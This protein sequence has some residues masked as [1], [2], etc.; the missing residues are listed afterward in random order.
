MRPLRSG[1]AARAVPRA[2]GSLLSVLVLC[3]TGPAAAAKPYRIAAAVR[4][5]EGKW[6]PAAELEET[7]EGLTVNIFYLPPASRGPALQKALGRDMDLLPGR[8]DERRPGFHVFVLRIDNASGQD[9]LFNPTQARMATEK[10]DLK[11]ALDYSAL[12]EESRRLGPQGPSLDEMASVVFDRSVT[13]REGGSVSKLLAFEAPRDDH[14]KR[15]EVR[16]HDLLVGIT[17][18]D[19]VFHFRKF[20]EEPGAQAP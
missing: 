17:P 5:A 13:I 16:L 8:V 9:L 15:L 6:R 10:G 19:L 14:Y 3:G 12:Y 4:D 1:A 7:R 2:I 20:T 18:L 11:F